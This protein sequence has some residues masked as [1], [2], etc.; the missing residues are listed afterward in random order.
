MRFSAT[1]IFAATTYLAV[2]A[3]ALPHPA[4]PPTYNVV[5]VGG[6]TSAPNEPATVYETVKTTLSTEQTVT[7]VVPAPTITTTPSVATAEATSTTTS[8]WQWTVVI[9]TVLSPSNA[10]YTTSISTSCLTSSTTEPVMYP[11]ET[12]TY[13]GDDGL[14]HPTGD[15]GQYRPWKPTAT[16]LST[17]TATGY[18]PLATASG[19]AAPMNETSSC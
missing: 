12:P 15:D 5:D 14:Y 6:P 19:W 18:Y 7:A 8:S 11:V 2:H 1:S 13:T 16:T 3:R 10:S 9:G 17:S 4:P